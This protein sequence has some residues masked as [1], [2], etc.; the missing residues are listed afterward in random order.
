MSEASL[1]RDSF[2]ALFQIAHQVL[3]LPE[4]RLRELGCTSSDV[5]TLIDT[6]GKVRLVVDQV[7]T[8]H[9]AVDRDLKASDNPVV[10]EIDSSGNI[11]VSIAEHTST[12]WLTLLE[13]TTTS[14]MSPREAFLR[15]GYQQE[16]L[17]GVVSD[18]SHLANT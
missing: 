9:F 6:V 8:V 10:T 16:E 3:E 4:V 2:K 12:I 5:S 11:S 13:F 7:T 17:A 15:T 18:F 14:A 1:S